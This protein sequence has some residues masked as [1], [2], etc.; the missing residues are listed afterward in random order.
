MKKQIMKRAWEIYR[1][2]VGD[3]IAKLSMALRQAW[4][5]AKAPA[6]QYSTSELLALTKMRAAAREKMF[7][8]DAD[9][10]KAY[11]EYRANRTVSATTTSSAAIKAD[12]TG[13]F[14]FHCSECG[15]TFKAFGKYAKCNCGEDTCGMV[16]A[17]A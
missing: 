6:K 17:V 10:C 11:E 9:L 5:E 4:A 12:S 3:R 14:T 1:T 8:A 2:L 15:N 7:A 16:K 13:R